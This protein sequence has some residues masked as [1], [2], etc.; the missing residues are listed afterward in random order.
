M[1]LR[2]AGLVGD[3]PV[4]TVERID[5]DHANARRAWEAMGEPEYPT[6]EQIEA[7]HAASAVGVEAIAVTR[8]G[9]DVV[10]EVVLPA[11]AVARVTLPG[12]GRAPGAARQGVTKKKASP[13][14]T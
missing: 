7:L 8:D 11:H 13:N 3:P 5:A 12:A 9:A 14:R 2:V 4:A 10:L 6:P 1:R